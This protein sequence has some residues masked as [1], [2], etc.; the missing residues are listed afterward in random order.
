[1]LSLLL[2]V[3]YHNI[4]NKIEEN[5]LLKFFKESIKIILEDS[6]TPED[7]LKNA[8]LANLFIFYSRRR[9]N[10]FMNYFI[11]K[12]IVDIPRDDFDIVIK[13]EVKREEKKKELTTPMIRMV[14]ETPSSNQGS[15]FNPQMNRYLSFQPTKQQTNGI[16]KDKSSPNIPTTDVQPKEISEISDEEKMIR[17]CNTN[18]YKIC[19]KVLSLISATMK[20]IPDQIKKIIRNIYE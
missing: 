6:K 4:Y 9:C 5:S 14:T 13:K 19:T 10:S 7:I 2:F 8:F 17:K 3:I 12:F 18:L 11:S 20:S 15:F 1:M 16:K